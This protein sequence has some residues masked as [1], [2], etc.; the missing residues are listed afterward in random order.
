MRVADLWFTALALGAEEVPT[1]RLG[2][3]TA[4]ICT[5]A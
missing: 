4:S 5:T 1:I 2:G 3:R